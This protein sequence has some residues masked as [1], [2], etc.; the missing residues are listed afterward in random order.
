MCWPDVATIVVVARR[1]TETHLKP[2]P[3]TGESMKELI[4]L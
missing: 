4:L 2:H 3:L 1:V